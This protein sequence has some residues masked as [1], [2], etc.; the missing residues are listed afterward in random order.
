MTDTNTQLPACSSLSAI[1]ARVSMPGLIFSG[2]LYALLLTSYI[3]LLP[4]FT[5]VQRSDGVAMTPHAIAEYEKDLTAN[6]LT[7]EEHRLVLVQPVDDPLYRSLVETRAHTPS[8]E[9][10]EEQL[11][12]AAARLGEPGKGVILHRIVVEGNAV[13]IEGDVRNVG[14]S[15]MTVLAAYSDQLA[16][17]PFVSELVR[18]SFIREK[19]PDGSVHSPFLFRFIR[20][21]L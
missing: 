4:A 19:L 7:A 1:L 13:S 16:A 15:S 6:L 8:I 17:L 21:S 20:T 9:L 11:R 18:P 14:L 2:S 12:Q 3:Y 10:M 5:N